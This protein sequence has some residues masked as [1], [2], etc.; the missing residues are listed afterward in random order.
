MCKNFLKAFVLFVYCLCVY[1]CVWVCMCV[2]LFGS[3]GNNLGYHF[4]SNVQLFVL[5]WVSFSLPWEAPC[6]LGWMSS[7]CLRICWLP[8]PSTWSTSTHYH[9]EKTQNAWKGQGHLSHL[10][11][12]CSSFFAS[13]T[14]S[15]KAYFSFLYAWNNN[16][17]THVAYRHEQI[18]TSTEPP[19]LSLAL[20]PCHFSLSIMT[21]S[22]V[23]SSR[24]GV[25]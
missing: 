18:C 13:W 3:E 9:S 19:L 12:Y 17:F 1:V 20:S 23:C 21:F 6:K 8:I 15:Y 4:L 10:W 2:P 11:N 7:K 25:G 16:A 24:P 14:F 22:S 5:F